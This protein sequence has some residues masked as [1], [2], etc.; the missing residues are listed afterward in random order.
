[1]NTYWNQSI[2]ILLALLT[3]LTTSCVETLDTDIKVN[4]PLLVVRASVMDTVVAEMT[5]VAPMFVQL[6]YLNP[7]SSRF[8]PDGQEEV[9][10]NDASVTITDTDDNSY[11]LEWIGDGRYVNVTP[12]IQGVGYQVSIEIPDVGLIE[13]AVEVLPTPNDRVIDTRVAYEPLTVV[14]DEGEA[15]EQNI[16]NLY[17]D[18]ELREGGTENYLMYKS[19]KVYQFNES[20]AF[21]NFPRNCYVTEG[22]FSS[23][24]SLHVLDEFN[25]RQTHLAARSAYDLRFRIGAHFHIIKHYLNASAHNFFAQINLNQDQSSILFSSLPGEVETNFTLSGEGSSSV[26]VEGYFITAKIDYMRV[27]ATPVPLGPGISNPCNN[28]FME[29][30]RDCLTIPNSSLERPDY[31]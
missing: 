1:M 3:V 25:D 29:R 9:L 4:A 23:A 10:I 7:S 2:I 12:G 24:A 16:V 28:G 8:T 15:F 21:T 30:C 14:T 13:S 19:Y 18:T 5:E 11:P 27:K 26:R 22:V 17:F 31:W 6:K 20:P